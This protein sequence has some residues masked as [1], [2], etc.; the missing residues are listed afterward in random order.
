M[1]LN[2]QKVTFTIISIQDA[3][4]LFSKYI[5]VYTLLVCAGE[6]FESNKP[7][8][9][10]TDWVLCGTWNDP[11]KGY[12]PSKY[13]NCKKKSENPK[14]LVVYVILNL[15]TYIYNATVF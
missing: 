9:S 15:L 2:T 7:Q 13:Q 6:L 11:R 8:N 12:V 4:D 1:P 14:S 5:N 3:Q 10:W